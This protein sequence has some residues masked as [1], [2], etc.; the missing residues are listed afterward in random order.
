MDKEFDWLKGD[1]LSSIDAF[2]FAETEDLFGLLELAEKV[3][4]QGYGR[5]IT[6]SKKVFIPL[7]QLCRDVCHYCTFSQPPRNLQKAFL[8]P[9]EV[10]EIAI[11]GKRAGC[12]EA[13]FTLGDKPELR[14][15]VARKELEKLGCKTTLEY[16]KEMA[17]LVFKE[18]GLLPHLNPG[19]MSAAEITELKT[20]S[21]SMGI[22]L[23]SSSERLTKKGMCH[24]GSPDKN[25]QVRLATI[26]EA[27]R[28]K[29]PFTTGLL[30]GI[31]ETRIERV[32]TLLALRECHDRY[33]HIQEIVIQNFRA[34]EGTLMANAAEPGLEDLQ[35]TIALARLIFGTSMSIQAPPNLSYGDARHLVKAGINDWGGVSPITPDHVNPEAP[36]PHLDN[37]E[38]D[39]AKEGK[40]LVERLSIYPQYLKNFKVWLDKSLGPVALKLADSEG[41]A[42]TDEWAPGIAETYCSALP[43]LNINSDLSCDSDLDHILNRAVAGEPLNEQQIVRLFSARNLDFQEVSHAANELRQKV[44]GDEVKYAVNRNINY[45]NVC[46]FGCTFCAFSK[47]KT[48]ENLRGKPYDLVIE[49][50]VRRAEEAW[51]RGAT[52]VCLQGGIHPDYDG[53][54]YLTI[55]K[56][57]KNAIP[58]MHIHAF[59]P[60]EVY[61]GATT[62]GVSLDSFLGMLRDAGL[63]SLPGTAAEVLDDDVRKILCPDKLNTKQWLDIVATAHNVGLKTTSTIMFGHIDTPT[64]W[65]KH[66]MQLRDLQKKTQGITEFVPLPFVHMEAPIYLRGLARPG[67]T[68]RETVLM[69]SVARLV[70]YPCI[71]NIQTSWVKLGPLGATACL[72]AGANDLGGTLMN[73]TITRSAGASHGQEFN[74]KQMDDLINSA[75]RKS[76]QRT[77]LYGDVS[78]PQRRKSYEAAPLKDVV[79]NPVRKNA[80]R[81][82]KAKTQQDKMRFQGA[83]N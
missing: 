76:K 53:N 3:R 33:G 7:T 31:G 39:T 73:E 77:T 43:N 64:N 42:R 54:T 44:V 74:P 57:I 78:E 70:L 72:N 38:T 41:M 37:L 1:R 51:E 19:V 79:N 34:K 23:E 14:Y 13:L 71:N 18:T 27:G 59:S 65:A 55:T 63:G 4:D 60:L 47:G 17:A 66:L 20:V 81:K 16:L 48:A 69:H 21:A 80:K 29:V 36:W 5:N 40:V 25:P 35:W 30:I 15:E 67:P 52:E 58:D 10:L 56:E 46:Y 50:I 32:E 62:L 49:E 9:D 82:V 61:Q 6:Y 28:Q 12:K 24:Y 26:E 2:S 22:M 75:G 45:T 83:A 68:W 11:Q 8:S